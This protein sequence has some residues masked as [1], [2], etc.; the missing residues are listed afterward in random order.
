MNIKICT[1]C[2]R[3]LPA[4]SEYFFK[5]KQKKDG[6]RPSCRECN[7]SKFIKK[8]AVL[9]GYKKCTKCNK[10]L[11]ATIDF[12]HQEK[13][14]NDGLRPDCKKCRSNS[15]KNWYKDNKDKKSEYH[16]RWYNQ[17]KRERAKYYKNWAKENREISNE[18]KRLWSQKRKA[19]KKHLPA[20]LTEEQWKQIKQDFDHQCAYCG[21]SEEEH[22]KKF[23]ETLHQE[24]FIP[25]SESGEYTHNNIIPACKSCNS[26]KNNSD[27][28][29]WYPQ[30]EFYSK[31]KEKKI[32]EYLKL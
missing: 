28:F 18:N 6:L 9:D 32:L 31:E 23:N 4:T 2:D 16:K 30:Q 15:V 19:I 24:H 26:S 14:S 11:P 21:M 1:K 8:E 3:E 20:T 29:E 13:T 7:G 12:F 27:F 10:I 25:L 5:D 17:N 22:L